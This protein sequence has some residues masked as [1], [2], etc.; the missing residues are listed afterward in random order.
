ML[1]STGFWQSIKFLQQFQSF[2]WLGNRY[3]CHGNYN[4]YTFLTRLMDFFE[5]MKNCKCTGGF[6]FVVHKQ[7]L[8]DLKL[9]VFLSRHKPSW[10]F[11]TFFQ[12]NIVFSIQIV[13][14]YIFW[15]LI[16]RA[17]RNIILYA[18]KSY[19]VHP[20]KIQIPF[21][22]AHTCWNNKLHVVNV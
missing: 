21:E 12:K 9:F 13:Q 14:C 16:N 5:C 6:S 18:Y 22:I 2:V 10:D 11:R 8:I 1:Y 20:C 4:Y 15:V 7:K 19:I 3:V 17:N